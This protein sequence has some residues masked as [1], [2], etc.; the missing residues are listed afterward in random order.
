MKTYNEDF[1][2]RIVQ[3]IKAGKSVP[4]LCEEFD[5]KKQTVYSWN[6]K[7]KESE[8]LQNAPKLSEAE[9]ELIT[10]KKELAEERM[11]VDL[12]KQVALIMG[13]K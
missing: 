10:V 8:I 6:K 7:Y 5:L 1:K 3:L 9:K 2:L 4:E 12:L 13:G 11:K